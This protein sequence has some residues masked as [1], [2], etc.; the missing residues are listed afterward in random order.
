MVD[1]FI[2]LM[3]SNSKN[4]P[5]YDWDFI[6]L[7]RKKQKTFGVLDIGSGTV[8]FLV[9]KKTNEK[10]IILVK[11]I[12][13]YRRFG[14]FDG[15]D[16]ESEVIREATKKAIK[17]IKKKAS[18]EVGSLIIG[19]PPHIFKAR[20]ISQT[21][22]REQ[23]GGLIDKQEEQKIVGVFFEQARKEAAEEFVKGAGILPQDICFL[24]TNIIDTK[25]DG[26]WIQTNFELV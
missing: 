26:Y 10:I 12:E 16:F 7:G 15:R 14:V 23:P 21:L 19:F 18:T 17:Q 3:F 11:A 24:T 20:I 4:R 8:K 25:I 6:L 2:D 1:L 5:S 9:L 22:E 13:E